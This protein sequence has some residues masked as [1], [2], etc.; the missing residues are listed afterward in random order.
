V[1]GSL[2]DHPH[3]D[4]ADRIG[5][6]L[7]MPAEDVEVALTALAQDGLTSETRTHWVLTRSGWA[8]ARSD[9]PFDDLE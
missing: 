3:D 1:L 7:A 4:T 5:R 8:S 9:D 2:R 6:L